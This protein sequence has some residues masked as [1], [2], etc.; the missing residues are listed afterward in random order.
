MRRTRAINGLI[1][2]GQERLIT[3]VHPYMYLAAN[4]RLVVGC[5]TPQVKPRILITDCLL[6]NGSTGDRGIST[7]VVT[8]HRPS[9][10]RQDS[11]LPA[12]C[13]DL[14]DFIKV[15]VKY[16]KINEGAYTWH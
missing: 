8:Q 10:V 2:E 11:L 12:Y 7:E 15:L 5:W 16:G 6:L 13:D 14:Q 9:G 3:E 4:S 1:K